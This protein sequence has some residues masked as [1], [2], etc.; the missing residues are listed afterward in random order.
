MATIRE[1]LRECLNRKFSFESQKLKGDHLRINFSWYTLEK[2]KR[3]AS[4]EGREDGSRFIKKLTVVI[5]VRN[6]SNRPIKVPI[7]TSAT[8]LHL[9]KSLSG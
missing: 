3:D 7:G 1:I 6:A 2:I 9:S 4:L 5:L 8:P